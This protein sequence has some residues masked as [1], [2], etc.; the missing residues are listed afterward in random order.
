M[1]FCNNLKRHDEEWLIVE[2]GLA[3]V[4]RI[5]N[6]ILKQ[7]VVPIEHVQHYHRQGNS[8]RP[9][10]LNSSRELVDVSKPFRADTQDKS[11]CKAGCDF[12]S[13]LYD[14]TDDSISE[15]EETFVSHNQEKWQKEEEKKQ[16]FEEGVHQHQRRS[17]TQ[18]SLNFETL[19]VT[20]AGNTAVNGVYRWFAA[21]DR[22]VMF[23]AQGQ[24][25][26]MRGVNLSEYGDRYYDC[27]TIEEIRENVTRLY[28]V[29]SGEVNF[30]SFGEW[31]CI[32][33]TVPAPIVKGGEEHRRYDD[34]GLEETDESDVSL[35][36]IPN[37]YYLKEWS[38]YNA[39]GT[40]TAEY[41]A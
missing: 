15:L 12:E 28:A 24:Y 14:A 39:H 29:A 40:E 25:Q 35:S 4:H 33:G 38:V 6:P 2:D 41:V 22:F 8:Q 3:R 11:M 32:N 7:K 37:S 18:M 26:I 36:P 31:I 20:G 5:S 17:S 23:S 16:Y 9:Q 27:W 34:D 10:H 1:S 30:I 13:E 19:T 21:H